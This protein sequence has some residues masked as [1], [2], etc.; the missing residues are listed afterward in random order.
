MPFAEAELVVGHCFGFHLLRR[1]YIVAYR[2]RRPM[3]TASRA[4][5]A[6]QSVS[7]KSHSELVVL[8]VDAAE[9]DIVAGFLMPP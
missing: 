3:P 8:R 2:R 7:I 4:D 5:V 1:R 6:R 9:V